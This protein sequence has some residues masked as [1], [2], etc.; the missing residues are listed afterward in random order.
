FA[1]YNTKSDVDALVN[2]V[3]RALELLV[4]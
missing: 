1:P 2:A 4:D 3:D